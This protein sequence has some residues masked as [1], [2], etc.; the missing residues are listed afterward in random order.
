MRDE[1]F[2]F[3]GC[4]IECRLLRLIFARYFLYAKRAC[5]SEKVPRRKPV[6]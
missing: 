2:S 1:N 3:L 4:V 6:F 5:L